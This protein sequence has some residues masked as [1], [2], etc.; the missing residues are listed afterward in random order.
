MASAIPSARGVVQCPICGR[1]LTWAPDRW[2]GTFECVRCGQ[3]SDFASAAESSRR[4]TATLRR[5]GGP[6]DRFPKL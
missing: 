5:F 2:L 6:D 1:P 3:F 4:A